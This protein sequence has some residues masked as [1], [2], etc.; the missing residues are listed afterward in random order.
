MELRKIKVGFVGFGE[1]NSPRDL[2]E[3][4]CA[5]AQ[6]ALEK[7]GLEL[8]TTAPVSDDSAGMDVARAKREL[9]RQDFP[10]LVVCLAGWIPSH[11]VM[12]VISPFAHKPMIL[13]GLTGSYQDG[14]L[15][16][17]ADQAGTS[18]LRAPM[19]AIGFKFKYVYDTPETPYRAAE[20]VRAFAEVA[21]A[22]ALLRQSRIGMMGYRDMKL[23][24][25]LFDGL[26]LR[27]VV[28]TEVE[29]F[30]I[31]EIVRRMEQQDPAEIEKIAHKLIREWKSDKLLTVQVLEKS[32]RLYL[33]VMEKVKERNYQ[34]VSLIDVDGVKKLLGFTPAA[35]LMMLS[36]LGKLP[37]TPENDAL[38]CVTQL[39]VRY[40]TGQAAPYFEFYEFFGDRLLVGVPDYIPAAVAE[41][42][43]QVRLTQFGLLSE[44][45]LNVSKVKTGR[46][47][48]CRLAGVANAYQMHMVTGQAVSPRKW[49][50]A[51]WAPPAP[52]L[53]SL[54]VIL[55]TP[56][57]QFAEQVFCQHY[58]L[59]YGDQRKK[60]EDLCKLLGI[61][62]V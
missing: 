20:K 7:L 2:I 22:A 32:I 9:A 5:E 59:A 44:G 55:D 40:L 14:R 15:V 61:E 46:V 58:I 3:H 8:V 21:Q 24:A 29:N 45:V 26:S 36:D 1:V 10:L 6:K 42:G 37:T 38:G 47:T 13:W 4:K 31:L 17:T 34:A 48:L 16:T 60:I 27:R 43:V 11:A 19:E 33:A 25:T 35:A 62:V 28:G 30:E 41:G 51:G 50:E 49:E 23:H 54:E 18:A 56:V 39:I 53:P 57:E 12:D 52:Q